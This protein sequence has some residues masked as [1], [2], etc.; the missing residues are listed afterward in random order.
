MCC[1]SLALESLL[2]LLRTVSAAQPFDVVAL[3]KV[4]RRPLGAAVTS[5][6]KEVYVTNFGQDAALTPGEQRNTVWVIKTRNSEVGAHRRRI[7]VWSKRSPPS[8]G[9]L[10]PAV[11]C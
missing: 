3:V 9:R 1:L 10:W 8:R 4:G 2:A 5:D 11:K 7:R 6:D